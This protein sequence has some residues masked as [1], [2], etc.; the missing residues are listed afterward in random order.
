MDTQLKTTLLALLGIIIS[1]TAYVN[2]EYRIY[3]IT[4]GPVVMIY[5][6][7]FSYLEK[8]YKNYDEIIKLKRKLNIYERVFRLELKANE[9]E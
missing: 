3:L 5:Y 4:F 8:I 1:L 9:N 6:V 7:L 2:E